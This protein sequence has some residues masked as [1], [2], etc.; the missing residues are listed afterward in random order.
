MSRL[1]S[2]FFRSIFSTVASNSTLRVELAISI[3]CWLHNFGFDSLADATRCDIQARITGID[4]LHNSVTLRD[5]RGEMA[6]IEISPGVQSSKNFT[7]GT[8]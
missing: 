4:T 6:V 8:R 2:R 5:M 1:T 3:L 7:W